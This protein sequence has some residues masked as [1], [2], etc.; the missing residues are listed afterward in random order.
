MVDDR[1]FRELKK[2][3]G[4]DF[5]FSQWV[6]D[7]MDHELYFL[8]SEPLDM[9]KKAEER[10]K[11]LYWLYWVKRKDKPV[12]P[13][14]FHEIIELTEKHPELTKD[15]E[16]STLRFKAEQFISKSV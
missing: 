5:N 6:R 14:V 3:N 7:K 1:T 12:P 13:D 2:A 16:I 10:L 9:S 15:S 8:A 11:H 4:T